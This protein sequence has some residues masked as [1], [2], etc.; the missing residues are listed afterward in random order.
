MDGAI[1]HDIPIGAGAAAALDQESGTGS[2]EVQGPVPRPVLA[3]PEPSSTSLK[4]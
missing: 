4:T 1:Y 3:H 2:K